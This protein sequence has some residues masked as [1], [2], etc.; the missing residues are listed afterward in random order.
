MQ[1]TRRSESVFLR[2]DMDDPLDLEFLAPDP[3]RFIPVNLRLR[4]RSVVESDRRDSLSL[5][6]ASSSMDSPQTIQFSDTSANCDRLDFRNRTDDFECT[7]DCTAG[8]L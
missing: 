5:S 8:F 1:T 7:H 4:H 3:A 2:T 6:P